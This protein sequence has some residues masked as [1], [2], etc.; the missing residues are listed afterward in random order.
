MLPAAARQCDVVDVS[1][2]D[3]NAFAVDE[4]TDVGERNAAARSRGLRERRAF[5][6][7]RAAELVVVAA[8][9]LPAQ[10]LIRIADAREHVRGRQPIGFHDRAE[11]AARST[12]SVSA[13]Q[14]CADT[15]TSSGPSSTSATRASRSVTRPPRRGHAAVTTFAIFTA[16]SGIRVS[17]ASAACDVSSRSNMI[18]ATS[19]CP[20]ARS[21]TRPPRNRRRALRATSHDS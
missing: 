6:R 9:E 17:T 1:V 12:S 13:P 16:L 2:D 11:A 14:A 21:T 7:Y 10:A 3:A 18:H 4:R 5:R 20:H 8:G 15:T 19:A